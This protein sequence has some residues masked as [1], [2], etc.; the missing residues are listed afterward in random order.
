MDNPI[1]DAILTI[2]KNINI[3]IAQSNASLDFGSDDSVADLSYVPLSD[4]TN[5]QPLDNLD[6]DWFSDVA[7]ASRTRKRK[8]DRQN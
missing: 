2:D 3:D 6:V 1:G 5:V 7:G 4:I 8:A